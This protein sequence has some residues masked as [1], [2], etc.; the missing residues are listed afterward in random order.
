VILRGR[1]CA[2]IQSPEYGNLPVVV[3]TMNDGEQ[4]GEL[5][6]INLEKI[7]GNAS[8]LNE[9]NLAEEQKAQK[10]CARRKATCITVE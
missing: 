10:Q 3:A 6:L 8:N 4:F 7:E 9:V 5:S 1:V 2:Q